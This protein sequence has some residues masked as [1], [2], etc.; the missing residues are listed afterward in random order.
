MTSWLHAKNKKKFYELLQRKTLDKK[1]DNGRG[2]HRT[3][4]HGSR[5]LGKK[6]AV[7]YTIKITKIF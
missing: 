4:I 6:Y 1:T 5:K 3:I 7:L 2:F